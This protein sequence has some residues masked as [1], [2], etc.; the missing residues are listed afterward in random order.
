MPI[1]LP[2][3]TYTTPKV[4]NPERAKR[5][6]KTLAGMRARAIEDSQRTQE[7]RRRAE[8]LFTNRIRR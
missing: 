7:A 1:T 2:E 3:G 4:R 8:I 5:L 6:A